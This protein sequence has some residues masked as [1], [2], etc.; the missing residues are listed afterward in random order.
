MTLLSPL[1]FH[2]MTLFPEVITPYMDN[3]VVG[4]AIQR[5]LIKVNTVNFRDFAEGNYRSVD[6]VP[7][8]GGPGVVI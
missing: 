7:F 5:N 2:F 1:H 3:G 8:G 4:R 6:D